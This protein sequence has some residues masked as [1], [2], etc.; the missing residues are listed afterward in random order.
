MTT[1]NI[2]SLPPVNIPFV[3]PNGIV[4]PVWAK[5]LQNI[6]TQAGGSNPEGVVSLQTQITTLQ[7]Q[8]ATIN[9]NITTINTNVSTLNTEVHPLQGGISAGRDL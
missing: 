6:Y 7:T 1:L 3:G 4:T 9:S 5:W 2:L 8:V